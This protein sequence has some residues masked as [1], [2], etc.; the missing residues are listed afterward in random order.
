MAE[1]DSVEQPVVEKKSRK[2]L[3]GVLVTSVLIT[4]A[5]VAG[6]I[7]GPRFLGQHA[8][9]EGTDSSAEPSASEAP[10]GEEEK[11]S[12]PMA[13]EAVIVDV[14]DKNSQAHNLKVGITAE[15]LEGITKEE[16]LKMMP[17]GRE[18]AIIYLRGK[19]Y[20]ELTEPA[21]FAIVIKDLNERVAKAMGAKH[22]KRIVITD[23]VAQ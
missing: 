22:V 2:R 20:E 8:E 23:F 13:F 5:G 21:Q 10:E 3:L 4:F 18:A 16:F 15:L 12:N 1:N 14:R 11:P 7:L 6:T 9:T 19:L 17:R